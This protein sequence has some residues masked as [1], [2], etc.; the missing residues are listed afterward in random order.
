[1]ALANFFDKIALGAAKI[2]KDYDYDEFR[3]TLDEHCVGIAYDLAST[4][5]FEGR[6]TLELSV[7][8]LSR[9][10][11]S[12]ALVCQDSK[13]Q[14]FNDS[15]SKTARRINPEIDIHKSIEEATEYIVVGAHSF[16]T[17]KLISYLGSDDWK[18]LL[19]TSAPVGSGKSLNPFGAAAAA[20]FGAANVFRYIFHDQLVDPRLDADL[21]ISML[22]YKSGNSVA[23]NLNLNEIDLGETFIVG[24]GAIGNSTVWALSRLIGLSGKIHLIDPEKIELSNLQRYTLA[25][26]DEVN[27][28]KVKIASEIFTQRDLRVIPHDQTWEEFVNS[29]NNWNMPLVAV[30]VDSAQG[31]SNVQ[32]SL[33][34]F[35][36]NAWTQEG[37]LGV[38]RHSFI[39][40]SACLA[41]LYMPEGK[42]PN[43]DQLVAEAINMPEAL[44]E[45]RALL[46]SN[47]PIGENFLSRVST[48]LDVP[49]ASIAKFA[50]L[51]LSTFYSEAVCGGTV[52][53]LMKTNGESVNVEVPMCFESA[54]A[55]IMLAAEIV[56][57]VSGYVL[58][59]NICITRFDLLRPLAEYRNLPMLKHASGECICQD[60]DYI[61]AYRLKYD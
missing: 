9:L 11:P 20:C 49:M 55:G 18:A 48:A 4:K 25:F 44:M 38:S 52:L 14:A 35:V 47:K 8:L 59:K 22:N 13:G 28:L 15:L 45:I 34:K 1:M 37:D 57:Q 50:E 58:P 61:E 6:V 17:D 5:S 42:L 24:L 54:M 41:C 60:E 27:R 29:R 21:D 43:D 33:P 46:Y 26:Q 16:H 7:S 36:I 10:Y 56:K 53:E 32:A 19:S 51:P 3:K 40:K 2:I 12:I 31:R 39:G 23:N 30:S